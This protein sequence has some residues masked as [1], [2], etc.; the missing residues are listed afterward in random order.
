MIYK[1]ITKTNEFSYRQELEKLESLYRTNNL[2]I[3]VKKTYDE[4]FVDFRWNNGAF[5]CIIFTI[6]QKDCCNVLCH[7]AH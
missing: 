4:M 5:F 3:S 6:L 1:C 7:L 2:H